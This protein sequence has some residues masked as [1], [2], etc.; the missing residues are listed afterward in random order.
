[1]RVELTCAPKSCYTLSLKQDNSNA[2][3]DFW[4]QI[5]RLQ[6][7]IYLLDFPALHRV[8]NPPAYIE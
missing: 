1:M 4:V 7:I 8:H 3:V 6:L 2:R 5:N